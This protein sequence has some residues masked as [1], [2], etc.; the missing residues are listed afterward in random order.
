VRIRV[1]RRAHMGQWSPTVYSDHRVTMR[2]V[3]CVR[4]SERCDRLSGGYD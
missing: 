4:A 3:A 2:G 1:S